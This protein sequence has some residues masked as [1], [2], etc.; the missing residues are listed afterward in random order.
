VKSKKNF[1]QK[2]PRRLLPQDMALSGGITLI[3]NFGTRMTSTYNTSPDENDGR[4]CINRWDKF[5]AHEAKFEIGHKMLMMLYLG[6]HGTYLFVFHIP[7]IEV[8]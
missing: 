2:L 1:Q 7:D 8:F 6:D 4:V 3:G 5:M